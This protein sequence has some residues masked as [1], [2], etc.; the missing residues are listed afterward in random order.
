LL[1]KGSTLDQLA[2]VFP[3]IRRLEVEVI[4]RDAFSRAELKGLESKDML[5]QDSS[6]G[7]TVFAMH[8]YG[9]VSVE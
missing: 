9:F 7:G 2:R 1:E 4:V 5:L 6:L 3:L 8:N